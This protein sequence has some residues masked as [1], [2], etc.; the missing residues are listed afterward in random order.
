MMELVRRSTVNAIS[1]T[2]ACGERAEANIPNS[3]SIS[4]SIN[5]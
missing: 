1:D 5:A 4:I 2:N 3:I